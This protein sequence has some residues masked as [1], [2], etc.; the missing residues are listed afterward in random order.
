[1]A[2]HDAVGRVGTRL[3][4]L[5]MMATTGTM[6]FA[7][8]VEAQ[9]YP[10]R[11]VR[12]VVP[13]APGGGSDI[14]AR[15]IGDPISNALG[16]PIIIDNKPGSGAVIGADFVAKSPADG[17]TLL[18]TTAGPQITNPYLLP[19]LPYDPNKD[20]VPVALLA[21]NLNVLVVSPNVPA[22]TVKELID[23]AKANPG[24]V[25]FSS[26]GLGSSSHLSGE[27]FKQLAGVDIIHV[28]YRGTGPAIQD[29]LAGRIEMTIDTVATLLPHIQS[30]GLRPLGV[31][32]EQPN[33]ALPGVP[34]IAATLPGF[35]GSSINY[36]SVPA[37]TPQPI[38]ERLNREFST[39]M[40][41]DDIS[42]RMLEMG[43]QSATES[44]A[45]LASR[46][47]AEQTK[48]RAVIEKMPKQ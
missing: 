25:S 44:Q 32:T 5:V 20:L 1:M 18:Y 27:M 47:V 15:L 4:A 38:I 39:V 2:K 40:N 28:P 23:Y 8:G 22:K 16:K 14:V 46:I 13:F 29:L 21:K 42:K 34:T 9:D 30:G 48:W 33:P 19:S 6:T 45:A 10:N 26:S 17:Y 11:A 31:A 24:K 36:I 41:R 3:L 43:V 7:S 37:G 35:E 12:L